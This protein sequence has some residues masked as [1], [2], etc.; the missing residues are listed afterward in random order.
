MKDVRE[1]ASVLTEK[2]SWYIRWG[3]NFLDY[4]VPDEFPA[5]QVGFSVLKSG[6]FF[7]PQQALLMVQSKS[8]DLAAYF[9][10]DIKDGMF[11]ASITSKS[12]AAQLGTLVSP[13]NSTT[14]TVQVPPSQRMMWEQRKKICLCIPLRHV[15]ELW[16][17]QSVDIMKGGTFEVSIIVGHPTVAGG[18]QWVLGEIDVQHEPLEDGTQP[19]APMIPSHLQ[20]IRKKPEIVHQH[21]SKLHS[22]ALWASCS[23]SNV[24]LLFWSA[25]LSWCQPE[26]PTE[27]SIASY[28][29]WLFCFVSCATFGID[30]CFEVNGDQHPEGKRGNHS[31]LSFLIEHQATK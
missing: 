31:C 14:C 17:N 11:Q 8:M 25:N 15:I 12:I 21:V 3:F 7:Q 23:L 13:A 19:P 24:N 1:T 22:I 30:L 4:G 29:D 20:P 18:A 28:L 27:G 6:S 26:A 9:G 2:N 10:A 16:Q 5:I